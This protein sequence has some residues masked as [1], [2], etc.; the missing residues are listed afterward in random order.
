MF[1][2]CKGYRAVARLVGEVEDLRQMIEIIKRMVTGQRLEEKEE[3]QGITWQ[4]W[5]KRMRRRS[6]N[7]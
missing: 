4:D 1:F 5:K 6:A 2:T 7:V 3:K